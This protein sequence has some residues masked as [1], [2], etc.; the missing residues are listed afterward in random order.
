MVK[1]V[2][3]IASKWNCGDHLPLSGNV[4]FDNNMEMH[5]E[6]KNSIPSL[7]KRIIWN[8]RT[9]KIYADKLRA[10]LNSISDT[11][12]DYQLKDMRVL[13]KVMENIISKLNAAIIEASDE[14]TEEKLL[15]KYKMKM[16]GWWDMNIK[17]L[18]DEYRKAKKVYRS[19]RTTINKIL[20]KK[21]K[22]AFRKKQDENKN[23]IE[24]NV[25]INIARSEIF[26]LFSESENRKTV[27]SEKNHNDIVEDFIQKNKA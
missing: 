13:E 1:N 27:Q 22:T 26:K 17:Q 3:I 7:M 16:N 14:I 21:A 10:L 24:P 11:L 12:P 9:K 4:F 23:K 19:D 18:Y 2:E 25:D 8:E 5:I 15:T 6:P 20:M